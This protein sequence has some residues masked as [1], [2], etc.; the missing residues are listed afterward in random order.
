MKREEK[1]S[2]MLPAQQTLT[3]AKAK[4]ILNNL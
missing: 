4:Q 2:I 1:K 3:Q